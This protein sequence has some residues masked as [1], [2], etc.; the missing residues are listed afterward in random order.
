MKNTKEWKA[1]AVSKVNLKRFLTMIKAPQKMCDEVP[2]ID[3]SIDEVPIKDAQIMIQ[4]LRLIQRT[5]LWTKTIRRTIYL[6]K[7]IY[8]CYHQRQSRLLN[9]RF[10]QRMLPDQRFSALA[11]FKCQDRVLD[12]SMSNLHSSKLRGWSWWSKSNLHS[13]MLRGW[14]ISG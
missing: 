4:E 9:W 10:D 3:A 14:T 1:V 6:T 5:I 12:R 7:I 8:R 13:S 11:S 2:L